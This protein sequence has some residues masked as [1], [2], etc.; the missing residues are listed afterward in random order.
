MDYVIG[1]DIG[2]MSSKG[3]LVDEQ[4][5]I[6]AEHVIPHGMEMPHPGHFEQDADTVW[7]GEFCSICKSLLAK[8]GVPAHQVKAVGHSATSPC[9]VFLDEHNKALRQGILYGI[10]TR[11][12]TEQEELV[13][14]IGIDNLT[15]TGGC[16][17]SS[18]SVAPKILWIRKNEPHVWKDTKMILSSMGYITYKLTGLYT[19]N[20]FDAV[21]YTGLFNI[22]TKQWIDTYSELIA[23]MEYLPQLA[24]PADFVGSI[25]AEGAKESGLAEGTMVLP[26]IADAAAEALCA[27]VS[28]PKEMMLMLGTTAFF[29][30]RTNKLFQTTKFWPSNFL[31]PDEYVLTGGMSNCGSAITWFINQFM[32]DSTD[33]MND[34]YKTLLT[35]A[36]AIELQDTN[37]VIVPYFAG[38]RTPIHDPLAKAIFFGVSLSH[39]RGHLF[40]ALLEGI[41][42]TIKYN[43]DELRCLSEIETIYAIGGGIKNKLLL[44]FIAD[45]CDVTISIPD[46]D[47]GACFGDAFLAAKGLHAGLQLQD[48]VGVETQIFPKDNASALYETRYSAFRKLYE[49]THP[50]LT[51]P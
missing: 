37:P 24:N 27:G 13:E 5:K 40:H 6:L 16:S 19:Q 30:L 14:K 17:M 47:M 34:I 46:R 18:Q 12:T 1:I 28:K 49:I 3:V 20:S 35:E 29:I 15:A 21:A 26:G 9:L 39:T 2:S 50:L 25:H 11:A 33:K 31:F 45:I 32:K 10:D 43:I 48:W 23:P 36:N 4:G 8:S 7:W 22:F 38:E 42:Y 51:K 44:E 41:S